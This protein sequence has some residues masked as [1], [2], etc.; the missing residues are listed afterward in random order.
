MADSRPETIETLRQLTLQIMLVAAG[1]FGIVGGFISSSD[2]VFVY[3]WLLAAALIM[4]AISALAGYLLHGVLISMLHVEK[5][6]PFD[7]RLVR[8]GMAQIGLFVVGGIA[9][10]IFVVTNINSGSGN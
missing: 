4:F 9:F 3:A 8:L 6:D 7:K 1:V 5:F 10:T 2:K